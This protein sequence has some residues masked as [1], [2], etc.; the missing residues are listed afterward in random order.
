MSQPV[1]YHVKPEQVG[2]EDLTDFLRRMITTQFEGKDYYIAKEE[3]IEAPTPYSKTP[4][5]LRGFMINEGNVR[6][7]AIWF[8]VTAC[9]SAASFYSPR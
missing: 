4:R 7:H 5:K 3:I 8:D 9:G 6:G 1:F 2:K